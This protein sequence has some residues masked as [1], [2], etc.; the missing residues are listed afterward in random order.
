MT[1][2]RLLTAL[3]V[4]A[5]A[6]TSFSF[7]ADAAKKRRHVRAAPSSASPA[8][9][10]ALHDARVERGYVCYSDHFHYGSSGNKP[11]RRAAEMA[12]IAAWSSF[13]D[14][15]YGGS[16]ANYGRAGSKKMTCSQGSGGW[17]CSVEARPCR[18][19]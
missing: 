9:S 18:G 14:L 11:S 3:A 16:W 4:L 8:I 5:L 15:E 10:G 1:L 7:E 2:T 6:A 17:D 19:R 12:A 13:V